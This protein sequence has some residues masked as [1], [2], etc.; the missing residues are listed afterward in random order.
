[1]VLTI[2]L[3]VRKIAN[4]ARSS[5]DGITD[6]TLY[7]HL[8]CTRTRHWEWAENK[9]ERLGVGIRAMLGRESDRSAGSVRHDAGR[10]KDLSAMTFTE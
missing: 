4:F 5:F 7:S 2:G 1:M 8:I 6:T 10:R 3:E 9:V